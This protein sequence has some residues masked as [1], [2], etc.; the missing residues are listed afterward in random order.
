MYTHGAQVVQ[1]LL[2]GCVVGC[3]KQNN[4]GYGVLYGMCTVFVMECVVKLSFNT[5]KNTSE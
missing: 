4:Y 2:S 3:I 5:H 1:N